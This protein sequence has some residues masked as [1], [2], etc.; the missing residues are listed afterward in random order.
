VAASSREVGYL[1]KLI[2]N[3]ARNG[4]T[5]LCLLTATEVDPWSLRSMCTRRNT[6][7]VIINQEEMSGVA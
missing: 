1:E 3:G 7:I 4:V 5:D 2:E 6:N